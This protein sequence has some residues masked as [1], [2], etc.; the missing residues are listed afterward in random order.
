MSEV[1]GDVPGL[2]FGVRGWVVV[3]L[4]YLIVACVVTHPLPWNLGTQLPGVKGDPPV[5]LWAMDHFWT[6]L[7]EGKSPFITERILVPRGAN[8]MYST[9]VPVLAFFAFPFLGN[10]LLY[11]GLLTLASLVGAAAAMARLVRALTDDDRAAA[12]AGLIYGFSPT[13][14]SLVATGRLPQMSCVALMPLAVLALVRFSETGGGRSLAIVSVV[15]WVLALTQVYSMASLLVLLVVMGLLLIP[16]MLQPRRVAAVLIAVGANLFVA[17]VM[18][19]WILPVSDLTDVVSGGIGFTSSGVVNLQD[20]F[21]PSARNPIFGGLH[22][23]VYDLRNG[24]IPSYFLGWGVLVLSVVGLLRG[25]RDPRALAL[26]FGGVA[27]VSVAAGSVIRFGEHELFGPGGLPFDW[28]ASVPFLGLLDTPRRLIV[29]ATL[30]VAALAGI[31]LAGLVRA[32]GRGWLVLA[33]A[34]LLVAVEF[35]QVGG[36]ASPVPVPEIYQ[37]LATR[38]GARTVYEVG[39]G[40]ASSNVYLGLDF[41]TPSAF[42]MYWQ[43]LHRKPRTGGYVARTTRSTYGWFERAPIMGDLLAAVAGPWRGKTYSAD[44]VDA[45]VETFNLGHVVIPPGRRRGE[46]AG[47]IETLLEGWIVGREEDEAGYLLYDLGSQRV[48]VEAPGS[49]AAGLRD[50]RRAGA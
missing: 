16:R 30:P 13:M 36:P 19:T 45:F 47:I 50:E 37:R 9:P 15:L 6:R 4:G 42:L 41:S 21:F 46:Y 17:W 43:T 44:E 22:E 48:P 14:L 11:G 49:P 23:S 10:L 8:M 24:D 3:T 38:P 34:V 33:G 26:F 7:G 27:V 29:A 28:L 20:L 40:L 39:G 31:G 18:L 32:T 1:R 12:L 5:I 2:R 35:G 25:W